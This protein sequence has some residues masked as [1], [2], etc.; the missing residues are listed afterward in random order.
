[1]NYYEFFGIDPNFD[2]DKLQLAFLD[3]ITTI[4]ESYEENGDFL[5][6][7]VTLNMI[8]AMYL[9]LRIEDRRHDYNKKEGI[10]TFEINPHFYYFIYTQYIARFGG[11]KLNNYEEKIRQILEKYQETRYKTSFVND[12]QV[13]KE[14]LKLIEGLQSI[15]LIDTMFKSMLKGSYNLNLDKPDDAAMRLRMGGI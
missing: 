5:N 3:K 4:E 10:T 14:L 13:R 15:Q 9:T 11:E 1:M 7:L 2:L 12:F 6:Q 8:I